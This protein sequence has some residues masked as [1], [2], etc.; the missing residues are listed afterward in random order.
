MPPSLED[1]KQ[2]VLDF[3]EVGLNQRDF[4]AASKLMVRATSSTIR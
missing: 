1:N 4:E 2:T 3:Y